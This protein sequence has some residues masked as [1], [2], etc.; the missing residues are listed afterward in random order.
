M[1][2]AR[3]IPLNPSNTPEIF[4]PKAITAIPNFQ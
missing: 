4:V 1:K 2:Q 3:I